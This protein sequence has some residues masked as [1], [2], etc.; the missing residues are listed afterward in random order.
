MNLDLKAWQRPLA[1]AH[2]IVESIPDNV[3]GER[4]CIAC[5]AILQGGRP[6]F[7]SFNPNDFVWIGISRGDMPKATIQKKKGRR[8]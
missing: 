8:K 6:V 5:G 7:D 2:K 4:R 3:T 1:C